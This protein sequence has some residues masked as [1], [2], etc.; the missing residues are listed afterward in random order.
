MAEDAGG[1]EEAGDGAIGED[2]EGPDDWSSDL[3]SA[4]IEAAVEACRQR[5]A[6]DRKTIKARERGPMRQA[7]LAASRQ[8]M[9]DD[10]RGT[11]ERIKRDF[12][13]LRARRKPKGL[14]LK[15]PH[16]KSL[17]GII[18]L[19]CLAFSPSGGWRPTPG[20]LWHSD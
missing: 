7:A 3:L 2:G 18:P 10:I 9:Q 19:P 6:I 14:G 4:L 20:R 1:A 17:S 5:G 15:H 8:R 11:V 13:A 12:G 16:G